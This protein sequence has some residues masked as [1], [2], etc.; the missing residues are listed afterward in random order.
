ME[1]DDMQA[2]ASGKV[3]PNAPWPMPGGIWPM[4]IFV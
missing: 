1:R 4:Q 2:L 3:H